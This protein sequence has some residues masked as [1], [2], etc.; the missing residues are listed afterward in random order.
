MDYSYLT[1]VPYIGI[2]VRHCADGQHAS[3]L[4][5]NMPTLITECLDGRTATSPFECCWCCSRAC[6]CRPGRT[7]CYTRSQVP[8][9]IQ[10]RC[11]WSSAPGPGCMSTCPPSPQNWWASS[12]PGRAAPVG[13]CF[14]CGLGRLVGGAG[15]VGGRKVGG[16]GGEGAGGACGS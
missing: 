12:T 9:A 3:S 1:E 13:A 4:S 14:M 7:A 15:H 11:S 8:E 5:P 10:G 6:T 2:S 16:W